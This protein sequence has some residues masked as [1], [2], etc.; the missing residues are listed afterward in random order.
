MKIEKMSKL[1]KETHI[2]IDLGLT[3]A[4]A[5]VYLTLVRSGQARVKSV[6]ELSKIAR[7]DI[8]RILDQL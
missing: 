4:Q 7:Q 2:L 3:K 1:E 6:R 8:Y 5:S